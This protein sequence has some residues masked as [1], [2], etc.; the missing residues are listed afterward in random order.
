MARNRAVDA[1]YN[2]Y[3]RNTE[4]TKFYKSAAWR[5]AR[6][7]KVLT[8]PYCELCGV[9]VVEIVH[10][11]KPLE[12]C[13]PAEAVAQDN[14]QS[15]CRR[16]HGGEHGTKAAAVSAV[17]GQ[18][19]YAEDATYR[20]DAD[21]ATR[22]ERFAAKYCHHYRG[23]LRGKPFTL[24]PIQCE[25]IRPVFGFVDR[26]TG[27]RRFT[28]L[29]FESAIGTGK[30]PLLAIAGLYGLLGDG[31]NGAQIYSLANSFG[32]ASHQFETAKL[33]IKNGPLAA[34]VERGSL[35]VKQY[36]IRWKPTDSKW[37]ITSGGGAKAGGAA[38]ML[39][40]DEVHQIEDRAAY[41]DLQGRQSK[42]DQPLTFCCTN[43]AKVPFSLYADLHE[44]AADTLTGGERSN[45]RLFPVIWA[46]PITDDPSSPATWRKANPLLG[47]TIAESK[48]ADEWTRA[49]KSPALTSRFR[50]QYL[51]QKVSDR[52]KWLDDALF[53]AA[54]TL[55]HPHEIKNA[56][57]YLG[58]DMSRNDDLCAL[59]D[60]YPTESKFFVV[61]RFILPRE[62][63]EAYEES[64]SI[65]YKKWAAAGA[66][67]LIEETTIST[68]VQERIAADIIAEHKRHPFDA[69]CYDRAYS[70]G[71]IKIIEAAGINCQPIG[72]GW[73]VA[74]GSDELSRRLKERSISIQNNAVMRF[75]ADNVEVKS[76]DRGNI[77]P[78][79]PSA[80]GKY[81]GKRHLKIDGI[82]ALVTALTVAKQHKFA[83]K[84]HVGAV[85]LEL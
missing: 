83:K 32:Q 77:W 74:S 65:P 1:A 73:G 80:K 4:A 39:L 48:V 37:E 76:D 30:T 22:F 79:K 62:T 5:R 84:P 34:F 53:A 55:I 28:S 36:E 35:V 2:K 10:H 42:R 47:V 12:R 17:V 23:S 29:W 14:L 66:I 63:A 24:H 33:F 18:R 61:P 41:D 21:K 51:G 20:Y 26:E 44:E 11:V 46:A 8:H 60:V 7:A 70:E 85:V 27:F 58:V 81:A 82:T 49:Q 9:H 31:E 64:H 43:A 56:P 57:R 15:T 6:A 38:S 59:I 78:V 75:C 40:V 25:I 13:T 16:C 54:S 68:A 3:Q 50:L 72:Q 19:V 67:E 69:V 45:P 52:E 71:V